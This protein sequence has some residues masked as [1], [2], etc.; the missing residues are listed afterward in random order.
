MRG[1]AIIT[2]PG[3]RGYVVV[4]LLINAALFT[5]LIYFGAS[6]LGGVVER[7]LPTGSTF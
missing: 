5:A 3:I 6:W 1:F 2:R 7:M 4:P